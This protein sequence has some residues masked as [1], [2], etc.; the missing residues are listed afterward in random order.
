MLDFNGNEIKR[1]TSHSATVNDI[2]IDETGE[3]KT[4]EIS[5]LIFVS[6]LTAFTD[7][8]SCSDDG[9]VV[10]HGL[11]STESME[12]VYHRPIVSLALDPDF[13]RKKTKSVN[14]SVKYCHNI[15]HD[16]SFS[17]RLVE[18]PVS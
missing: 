6:C 16:F 10:I 7:I 17:L 1:F 14:T 9:K 13:H 11:C 15:I 5:S 4:T 12:H 2:C 8:G 18:K 3:C